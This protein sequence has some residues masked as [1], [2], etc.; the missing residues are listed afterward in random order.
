MLEGL[1]SDPASGAGWVGIIV[2]PGAVGGQV[3]FSYSHLVDPPCHKL[4]Q[5]YKRVWG[6]GGGL[7]V[8]RGSGCIGGLVLEEHVPGTVPECPVC[9]S[10]EHRGRDLCRG[11]GGT[12]RTSG[13]RV[14]PSCKGRVR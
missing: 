3:A 11:R 9:S 6:E 13:K 12:C 7:F 14:R 5:S 4:L 2:E 8:I 1:V 10:H